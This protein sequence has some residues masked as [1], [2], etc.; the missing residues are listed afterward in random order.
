M[1][2]SP[3]LIEILKLMNDGWELGFHE[4]VSSMGFW[5]QKNG[6]GHGGESKQIHG[7]TNVYKLKIAGLIDNDGKHHFPTTPY[8]LTDKGKKFVKDLK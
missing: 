4:G 5:I 1:K 2:L 3:K 8:F 6:L 7:R